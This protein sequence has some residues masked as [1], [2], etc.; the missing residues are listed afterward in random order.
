M[1]KIMR[2][3]IERLELLSEIADTDDQGLGGKKFE[4]TLIKAFKLIGLKFVVNA[5][6]GPGW[7]IHT[8]GEKWLKLISEKDVNIKV[9]GTKWMLSSSELYKVLPWEKLPENFDKTKYERKI[10]RIFSKKGVSQIYFLKPKN[11]EIQEKIIKRTNDKDVKELE[12]I[13]IKKNFRFE[14][15]GKSFGVKI[16]DNGERV[17]SVAILKDGKVFMRSEK[18]RKLGGVMTVTFRTPTP[19]IS[20]ITRPVARI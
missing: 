17:T 11:K 7:D 19:K 16:L 3:L 1:L 20:K 10:R 18:P 8:T 6:S 4:K 2:E 12:K 15:L 9:Y 13:I 5:A 14:K